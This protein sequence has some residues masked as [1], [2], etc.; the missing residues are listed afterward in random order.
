[1]AR[2]D[3]HRFVETKRAIYADYLR[4]LSEL[5]DVLTYTAKSMKHVLGSV[6]QQDEPFDTA[7]LWHGA[8]ID[9]R[10]EQHTLATERLRYAVHLIAPPLVS[11]IAEL[12]QSKYLLTITKALSG[13]ADE[14][15]AERAAFNASRSRL[16]QRMRRDLGVEATKDARPATESI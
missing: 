6:E 2:E 5:N 11:T 13:K 4:H 10:V 8:G 16:L 9:D 14:F 1:M 3:R 15:D 7:L 12:V